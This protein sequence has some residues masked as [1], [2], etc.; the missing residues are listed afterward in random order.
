MP[1]NPPQPPSPLNPYRLNQTT[2]SN[3]AYIISGN[4]TISDADLEDIKRTK[5][6]TNQESVLDGEK[7]EVKADPRQI[8][9][10]LNN[11]IFSTVYFELGQINSR[12]AYVTLT[13]ANSARFSVPEEVLAKPA[14]DPKSNLQDTGGSLLSDGS[15][16]F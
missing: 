16:G 2:L 8:P 5:P 11:Q 12:V 3:K 6:K 9:T 4:L 1:P 13:D 10:G 14:A 15:F 7:I